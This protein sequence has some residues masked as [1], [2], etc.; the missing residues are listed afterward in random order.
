MQQALG[1]GGEIITHGGNAS[2]G[3]GSV[4]DDGDKNRAAVSRQQ[5]YETPSASRH[6]SSS[7]NSSV[8]KSTDKSRLISLSEA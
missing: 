3:G 6:A 4:R 5:I 7:R 2:A 8:V 1:Y